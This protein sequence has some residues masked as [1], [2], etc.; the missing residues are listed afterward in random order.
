MTVPAK[1]FSFLRILAGRLLKEARDK[2]VS[3]IR[4]KEVR[5]II[6]LIV[7]FYLSLIESCNLKAKMQIFNRWL[8]VK[9]F[10]I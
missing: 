3:K 2:N 5:R 7:I 8:L 1:A 4:K 6:L 9:S 10:L